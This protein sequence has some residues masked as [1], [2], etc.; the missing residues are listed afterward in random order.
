METGK[1]A[2][3]PAK[4]GKLLS[5]RASQLLVRSVYAEF[6]ALINGFEGDPSSPV[7]FGLA[8]ALRCS[9]A[10]FKHYGGLQ[11]LS[12]S[13]GP[14]ALASQACCCMSCGSWQLQRP[15]S[16]FTQGAECTCFLGELL[17]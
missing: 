9:P 11:V 1:I 5:H 15:Q 13:L 17:Y 6:W 16:S 8:L 4:A 3:L 7:H 10:S 2:Q 12:S 14:L